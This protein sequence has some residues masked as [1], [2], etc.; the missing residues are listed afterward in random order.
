ML[1]LRE[2]IDPSC[3]TKSS[4]VGISPDT[5]EHP[6]WTIRSIDLIFEYYQV[7]GNFLR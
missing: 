2:K 3:I 7:H 6:S 1:F 4:G 5:L